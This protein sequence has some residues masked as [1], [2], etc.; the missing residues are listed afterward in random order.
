[1]I[2]FLVL[3]CRAATSA[4][5]PSTKPKASKKIDLPAPVSPVITVKL[6]GKVTSI[7]SINAKLLIYNCFNI[8][9]HLF[10]KIVTLLIKR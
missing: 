1:M 7:S 10:F 6:P 4:L 3:F 8:G 2:H 5:L 9:L